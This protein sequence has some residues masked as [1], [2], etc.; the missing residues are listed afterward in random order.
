VRV[1]E[2]ADAARRA[3][4]VVERA[5]LLHQHDD[6]LDGVET[7]AAHRLGHRRVQGRG[8][9]RAGDGRSGDAEQAAAGQFGHGSGP[10]SGQVNGTRTVGW[11][12]ADCGAAG[13]Q[14]RWWA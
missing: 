7:A 8:Q 5:V 11:L 9:Q 3:E 10:S 2:A 6:V 13:C 12:F 4:V 1:A 14:A